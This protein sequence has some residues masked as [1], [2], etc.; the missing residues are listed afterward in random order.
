MTPVEWMMLAQAGVSIGGSIYNMFAGNQNTIEQQNR[1]K[2]QKQDAINQMD[3]QVQQIG[4][5]SSV[6]QQ[7]IATQASSDIAA[8]TAAGQVDMGQTQQMVD[9]ASS[10]VMTKANRQISS[11]E[12]QRKGLFSSFNTQT[13]DLESQNSANQL[14][15][16][17][18]MAGTAIGTAAGITDR[19][20]RYTNNNPPEF[21]KNT[22]NLNNWFDTKKNKNFGLFGSFGQEF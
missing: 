9:R 20:S 7:D 10:D 18:N 19:L 12:T 2:K 6:A 5:D 15:S 1:L 3:T 14:N 17:L 13:Q 4:K 8:R 16:I 22:T 21:T 11:I